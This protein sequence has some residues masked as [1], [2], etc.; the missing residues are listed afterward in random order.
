MEKIMFKIQGSA[1]EPYITA[2]SKHGNKIVARCSC[3]A[4]NVGQLC[5]HR[6]NILQGTTNGIVS[7]NTCEVM[8]VVSWVKSTDVE[9]T[10]RQYQQAEKEF[11]E[12]KKQFDAI[13]KQ[14][15]RD[16]MSGSKSRVP[17]ITR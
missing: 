1:S 7:G 9:N 8:T 12:A 6:L 3:P 5:K 17:S 15:A 11:N 2:F 4:G 10:L 14:L 13:K 16:L